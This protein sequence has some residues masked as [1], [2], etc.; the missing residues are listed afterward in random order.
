MKKLLV[1]ILLSFNTVYYA[2]ETQ[3]KRVLIGSPIHQ[4]PAILKE[5]LASLDRLEK[6]TISVDYFFVDDNEIKESHQLLLDFAK[7]QTTALCTLYRNPKREQSYACTETTHY[8]NNSLIAKVAAFKNSIIKYAQANQYDCLFL[9]D[10]DIVLHPHTL[11]H[12][13]TLEKDIISEIF[14]T[15]WTPDQEELPQVWLTDIYTL[16][17]QQDTEQLTQEEINKRRS[18]FLQKL[19]IPGIYEVGGLGACTLISKK[20]LEKNVNFNKIKNVTFWGEDRHF[21]IRAAALDIPL[22]VD[23]HYPAYHIYRESYLAGV[24]DFINTHKPKNNKSTYDAT[25]I[26]LISN[27]SST[28]LASLWI[29]Y[30]SD[31]CSFNFIST[32]LC[33]LDE[34]ST[35]TKSVVTNPDKTHGNV[36][37]MLD[38]MLWVTEG[39]NACQLPDSTI[40]IAY[41]FIENSCIIQP[42][43][44]I[45]NTTFDA[46][47]V[48]DKWEKKVFKQCGVTIPIFVL[49]VGMALKHLLKK[50]LSDHK[51]E[52]FVFGMSGAFWERKN[53]I[54]VL[55]AF[56]KAFGTTDKVRLKLHGRG[57]NNNIQEAL[58]I[59][60]EKNNL[61]NVEIISNLIDTQSFEDFLSSLDC[62]M[63]VSRGEGYSM[64]PREAMALGIPC[65]LSNNTAHMTICNTGLVKAVET[66][67]KQEPDQFQT[68]K[69]T[70]DRG[71]QL[72]CTVDD[73]A[74]AMLDMYHNYSLYQQKALQAR[75]W[76]MKYD[77][78]NLK[79]K[80]I[81]LI[82]P[83]QVIL[84]T[85]NSIK[86]AYLMTNSSALYKK[87]LSITQRT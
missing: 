81:Q 29:D 41:S 63:L 23:T 19:R 43:V 46:V 24:Q 70:I 7:Q 60:I 30:L 21:C 9:I 49:P 86:G 50:P 10:S 3:K 36:T 71:Y 68:L 25:L 67:I 79:M 56:I 76:V 12:L 37:I 44:S 84:G 32:G 52:P 54:K 48:P 55:E 16:Y 58:A 31:T 82:K 65:I 11:E 66:P 38:N 69:D 77:F 74:Q 83:Q 6:N 45:L 53:H 18:D 42:W 35:L 33:N 20:A 61:H 51:H 39:N 85:K 87:Y 62:Y 14:W 80:Y 78:S 26:G 17:E 4:K 2:Q 15:K 72:N 40:K 5:F 1:L 64:S 22:F 8:W 75:E 27:F 73:L 59:L 34:A 57:G 47:V 13:I 28:K